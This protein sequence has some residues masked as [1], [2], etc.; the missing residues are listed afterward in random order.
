MKKGQAFETMMLVISVIVA[1][2]ILG[3]LLNI[4][5]KVQPPGND[6]KSEIAKDFKD[7][8]SKGFGVAQSKK[9]TF[10]KGTIVL[11]GEVKSD[12]PVDTSYI[13][14]GCAPGDNVVCSEQRLSV[15]DTQIEA[16]NEVEAY[17]DVCGDDSKDT[18]KYCVG[19]GST[20]QKARDT[21]TTL[22]DIS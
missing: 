21:C 17:A 9:L 16:V 13:K 3:V 19:I 1:I 2:A 15:T 5:T 18:I 4:I 7:I 20:P 11:R 22:C 10:K 8:Y 12:T 6:A 14:F